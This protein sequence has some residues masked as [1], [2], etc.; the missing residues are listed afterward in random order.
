MSV[1]CSYST[2]PSGLISLDCGAPFLTDP[3]WWMIG[4]CAVAI[5]FVFVGFCLWFFPIYGVWSSRK[6]GEA[7]LAEATFEQRIQIAQAD[8]RLQA[9]QKNKEAAV[10]E[11]EAVAAQIEKIGAGLQSHGLYL[12]WQWIRM[13]E[14]S[15]AYKETIYVPT[16]AN[17]PILEATRFS[18]QDQLMPA[19]NSD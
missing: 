19:A 3:N 6:R 18:Q 16:E 12:R 1:D 4:G 14:Q 15:E 17:L 9:A 2:K 11:A 8:G 13:M 5:I 7:D 10:I